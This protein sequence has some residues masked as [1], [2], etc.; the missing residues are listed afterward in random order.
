MTQYY[1]RLDVVDAP[2]TL[3]T[4]SDIFGSH[5]VS[6]NSVVQREPKDGSAQLVFVTHVAKEADVRAAL[7]DLSGSPVVNE[8][9]TVIR[10]EGSKE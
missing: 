3:A 4:T 7:D 6:I 10:V 2:G 9:A 8:V 5:G 1:I